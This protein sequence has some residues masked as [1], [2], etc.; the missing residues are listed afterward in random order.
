MSPESQVPNLR[1]FLLFAVVALLTTYTRG[2]VPGREQLLLPIFAADTPGAFGSLWTTEL[3]LRND[4]DMPAF[5]TPLTTPHGY[6]PPR[7]TTQPSF[8]KLLP[9]EP[10]GTFIYVDQDQHLGLHFNLRIRDVSRPSLTWGTELPV[11]PERKFARSAIVLINVP[12]EGRFRSGL[13]IYESRAAGTGAARIRIFDDVGG[14]LVVETTVALPAREPTD[15]GPGY[16]QVLD[17][18]AAFPQ[19]REVEVAR[20]EVEPIGDATRIWAFVSVTSNET[21]HVTTVTPQ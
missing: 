14:A 10:P 9:G 2:Q 16:T 5:V 12:L 3:W 11:V 1:R 7:S 13:R 4:T 6:P 18:R 19:L 15:Y 17:L 8:Y 20:I 21:Q